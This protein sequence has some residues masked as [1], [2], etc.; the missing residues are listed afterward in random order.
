MHA[1][2]VALDRLALALDREGDVNLEVVGSHDADRRRGG[3]E[4]EGEQTTHF[5]ENQGV[6]LSW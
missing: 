2:L 5:E 1:D 6:Q 3:Q 4:R